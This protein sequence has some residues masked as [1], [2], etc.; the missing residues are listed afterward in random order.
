MHETK[1]QRVP[2]LRDALRGLRSYGR[3]GKNIAVERVRVSLLT[4][5]AKHGFL[6]NVH[7][8]LPSLSKRYET[9]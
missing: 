1:K 9:F 6:Q 5:N 3:G 8:P 7:T 2:K 4:L